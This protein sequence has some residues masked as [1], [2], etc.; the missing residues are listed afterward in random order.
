MVGVDVT[1]DRELAAE[2]QLRAGRPHAV[3]IPHHAGQRLVVDATDADLHLR[4]DLALGRA[5]GG[6]QRTDE[7]GAGEQGRQGSGGGQHGVA[8]DRHGSVEQGNMAGE[9]TP[10]KAAPIAPC[11]R[12]SA[13]PGSGPT[14]GLMKW[15]VPLVKRSE[16][17]A[18]SRTTAW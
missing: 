10:A 6:E 11:S 2:D 1:G 5:P 14:H 13:G 9:A 17:L 15:S 16:P 8:A 3:R 12:K 4:A 18:G 7:G